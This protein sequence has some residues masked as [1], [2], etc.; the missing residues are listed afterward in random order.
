VL[1][2]SLA[3]APELRLKVLVGED[4]LDRALTGVCTTDLPDPRRYLS[5]GE[6][7][8]TGLMWRR[9]PADSES[10]AAALAEAGAAALAAGDA[11]LG[12]VPD[13]L[14]EACRRHGLPLL[15]VPVDV[16]FAAITEQVLAARLRLPTPGGPGPAVARL[17]L[18]AGTPNGVAPAG[19]PDGRR[20]GSGEP[21]AA[22]LAAVFAVAGGEY[23]VAGWVMSASG[24]LVAGVRPAPGPALRA[25][26]TR[27]WLG[28]AG[29]PATVLIAGAP[30]SLLRVVGQPTHR[31]ADWFVA[32]AGDQAG[33]DP[34]RR[35][36]AAEL[37]AMA[38]GYRARQEEGRQAIRGAADVVLRQVIDRRSG[39]DSGSDQEI[40]AGLVRCGL[41][42]SGPLTVVAAAA[43]AAEA[44]R[45]GLDQVARV[46]LEEMLPG[47]VA[48]VCGPGAVAFA[49]G[50]ENVADR[51]RDVLTA[52]AGVPGLNLAFGVSILPPVDPGGSSRP[53]QV[54][55]PWASWA[56]AG[57]A[58]AVARAR[59][60]GRL[61][62]LGGGVRVID[63]AQIGSVELLL[64]LVPGEARRAYHTTLLAPVLAY[65][66][67]HGTEL[68]STLEVFLRCSGSWTRAAEE[69]YVHVNSLRYRIRRIEELTGR[70]LGSLADQSAFLLALRLAGEQRPQPA[71]SKPDQR[72]LA[73][74]RR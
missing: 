56:V 48:G 28:A 7:V 2:R 27:A 58:D 31:L 11:A 68:A 73:G 63:A 61:A 71:E 14:I 35:A 50:G 38:A 16:S 49:P 59:Q 33:W 1:L 52:L 46:L 15:E 32:L 5:G 25:A 19:S 47:A 74:N 37:A 4:C 55:S 51:V 17:R 24:R 67:D 60:A 64:A 72:R 12:L 13:D 54:A 62:A 69:M 8:L 40:A 21:A 26:L 9:D 45:A 44:D 6:I 3:E 41:P 66:R 42:L 43:G 53:G 39:A 65:D 57:V 22:G 30:Y 29:I 36:I 18:L 70:D 20:P 23:G 34:G 10:F